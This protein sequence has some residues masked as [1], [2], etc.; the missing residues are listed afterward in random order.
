MHQLTH[1]KK[2]KSSIL[3]RSMIVNVTYRGSKLLPPQL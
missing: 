2:K 3:P 1:S